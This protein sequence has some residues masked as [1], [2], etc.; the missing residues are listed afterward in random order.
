MCRRR[1][2]ESPAWRHVL[3]TLPTQAEINVYDSLDERC[4]CSHFLGKTLED[5]QA[6]FASN[7]LAYQEDLMFMGPI[8][9]RYYLEAAIR[10]IE[11]TRDDV[12]VSALAGVL[13]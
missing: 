4:A 1:F 12:M 13:E 10:Y 3:M 11:A 7:A 6:L 9:F 8:A 2:D 5:A